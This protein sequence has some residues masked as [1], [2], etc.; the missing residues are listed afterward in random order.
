[1]PSI[2]GQVVRQG[3]TPASP[4]IPGTEVQWAW[5]STSIGWMMEC[6]RKY[7][8]AMVKGYRSKAESVHLKYGILY[9]KGLELFDKYKAEGSSFD[10]AQARMVQWILDATWEEGKPWETDHD[11]KNRESLVRSVIWYTEH[12]KNDPAQTVILADGSPAVELTFQLRLGYS[13]PDTNQYYVISGHTDRLVSLQEDLYISD[14]K[15][16]G[17]ALSSYYFS[18]YKPDAQMTIYTLA[19][20][21]VHK[22]PIKGVLIDAA[23]ILVGS[24]AFQRGLTYRTDE[25][26]EEFLTELE[27]YWFPQARERALSGNWPHNPKACHRYE[28]CQFREVCSMSPSVRRIRLASDF[29]EHKWNPLEAR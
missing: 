29:I 13:V 27:T 16:T 5:D 10:D 19:G 14:R 7:Y 23:Q 2:E 18:Q 12:Y 1:M 11:K 17:S 24:T 21:I 9:H 6:W 3:E 22:Q 25:E 20:K 28:G 26:L 4:F 15:T 8:Y